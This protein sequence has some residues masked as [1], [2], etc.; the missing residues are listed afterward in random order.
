MCRCPWHRCRPSA[1]TGTIVRPMLE[2]APVTARAARDPVA[3][4]DMAIGVPVTAAPPVAA[5]ELTRGHGMLGAAHAA[6]Q[7]QA[8]AAE[9]DV[10]LLMAAAEALF[11]VTARE[12]PR[13]GG[14]VAMPSSAAAVRRMALP[15]D[16]R[17]PFVPA[18]RSEA[19]LAAADGVP[20]RGGERPRAAAAA[21]TL[22]Q[23]RTAEGGLRGAPGRPAP[24][25]VVTTGPLA[26]RTAPVAMRNRHAVR[27]HADPAFF[28]PARTAAR[29]SAAEGHSARSRG[30][31]RRGGRPRRCHAVAATPA[32]LVAAGAPPRFRAT[33]CA[34][35]ACRPRTQGGSSGLAGTRNANATATGSGSGTVTGTSSETVSG[36]GPRT[37][38]DPSPRTSGDTA[39]TCP[40]P[41]RSSRRLAN[42]DGSGASVCRRSARR[43]PGHG[44]SPRKRRRTSTT[45]LCSFSLRPPARS[46]WSSPVRRRLHLGQVRLS[47]RGRADHLDSLPRTWGRRL[48]VWSGSEGS[49]RRCL[50]GSHRCCNR[51]RHR[52]RCS[53]RSRNMTGRWTTGRFSKSCTRPT[54]LRS[55]LT[56]MRCWPSMRGRRS[57]C[58]GW[59]A[60]STGFGPNTK[61]GLRR[62]WC[63]RHWYRHR[64]RA[65]GGGSPEVSPHHAS[66]PSTPAMGGRGAAI[67][68]MPGAVRLEAG[69]ADAIG[70]GVARHASPR[71][72][73]TIAEPHLRHRRLH[74]RPCRHLRS[75]PSSGQAGG[76]ALASPLPAAAGAA[77]VNAA[78]VLAATCLAASTSS[79]S[80]RTS[81]PG[82]CGSRGTSR[83]LAR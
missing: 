58:I 11:R 16:Q 56:S 35:V 19:A 41:A 83:R 60:R 32:V 61:S 31:G 66:V 21:R 52:N 43:R 82:C 44:T 14:G 6:A 23:N 68:R 63:R 73:L 71:C 50:R 45:C 37:G 55:W 12:R 9:G 59:C 30:R 62:S 64:V 46:R 20:G 77:A 24:A 10:V 25:V 36:H 39:C 72:R 65:A 74:V 70:A 15:Q 53:S 49:R 18:A 42:E 80:R 29:R 76:E 5:A 27:P 13:V 78:A 4:P 17:T 8:V 26:A 28:P 47:A 57:K 69:R 40:W 54:T 3:M 51:C 75:Q 79:R 81:R 38:H 34:P 7:S 2:Q 67:G 1:A 33:V 48:H 22:L